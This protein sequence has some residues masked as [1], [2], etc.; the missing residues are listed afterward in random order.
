MEDNRGSEW[1]K[2]AKVK[3]EITPG[4]Q[5]KKGECKINHLLFIDYLKKYQDLEFEVKENPSC[6]QSFYQL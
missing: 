5:L 6:R 1:S 3:L 4:Y 2:K